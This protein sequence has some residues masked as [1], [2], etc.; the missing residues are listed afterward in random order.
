LK[1][2]LEFFLKNSNNNNIFKSI[3]EKV[4]LFDY[5]IHM[6]QLFSDNN[7]IYYRLSLYCKSNIRLLKHQIHIQL[8]TNLAYNILYYIIVRKQLYHMYHIIK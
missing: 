4:G 5:M 3:V 7:I 6:V 1:K 2:N 8:Y